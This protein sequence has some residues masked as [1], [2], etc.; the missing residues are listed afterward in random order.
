MNVPRVPLALLSLVVAAVG[1]SVWVGLVHAPLPGDVWL[2]R[3]TQSI[4]GLD[5]LAEAVNRAGDL[6]WLPGGAFFAFWVWR[7]RR[8]HPWRPAV[9][10][11]ALLL[12]QSGSQLLKEAIDS[13]RPTA[14]Y[15]LVIDRLRGDPGFPSGHVYGDVLTYGALALLAPCVLP[16][17]PAVAIRL[18][19]AA[20]ILPAGWARVYVGAHW[21]SD[22]VGG[23]L[24]G[25]LA[26]A[27]VAMLAA[28]LLRSRLVAPDA[29]MSADTPRAID[30]SIDRAAVVRIQPSPP[31]ED[32]EA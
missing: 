5:T 18:A 19:A 30:E 2:A 9:L 28:R 16:R 8:G 1:L 17:A 26:L 32:N 13:P 15:G 27:T 3:R 29:R 7:E 6:R 24:W 10:G 23:Y 25:A 14:G 20:V 22:V 12:L 31:A 11:F 21:P 4:G